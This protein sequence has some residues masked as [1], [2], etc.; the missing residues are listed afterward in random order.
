M[1]K[2][3]PKCKEVRN[4]LFCSVC[5]SKLVEIPTTVEC[6]I[7]NH[8]EGHSQQLNQ[9]VNPS[10]AEKN[11]DVFIVPEGTTVVK[12]HDFFDHRFQ[13]KSAILPSTLK[14][15]GVEAFLY[16]EFHEIVIPEGVTDIGQNAFSLS[17]SLRSVTLPSTLKKIGDF[18]FAQ[19]GLEEITIPEGI[20]EIRKSTF[21]SCSLLTSVTLPST[22]EKIGAFA[23][24]NTALEEII[25]PESVKE[26]DEFAFSECYSLQSVK[27]PDTLPKIAPSAFKD[28]ALGD[29]FFL[30]EE[31]EGED[32]SVIIPEGTT[33]ISKKDFWKKKIQT[34]TLPTTLKIIKAETFANS[35]IQEIV[36]P[37][38][39]TIIEEKAFM[40]CSLLSSVTLPSTLKKI[41]AYAFSNTLL[42]NIIIPENVIKIEAF[43]FKGTM[44]QKV[45]IYE[46]N[47]IED[48][49][50]DDHI[51]IETLVKKNILSQDN[52]EEEKEEKNKTYKDNNNNYYYDDEEED[53][54]YDDEDDEDNDDDDNEDNEDN[55]EDDEDNDD[56][57]NDDEDVYEEYTV[58]SDSKKDHSIPPHIYDKYLI[59]CIIPNGVGE[60]TNNT[61]EHWDILKTITLPASIQNIDERVFDACKE[62][63]KINIPMGTFEH[64]AEM[65]PKY[66]FL[67][68][69]GTT[70]NKLFEIMHRYYGDTSLMRH[71]HKKNPDIIVVKYGVSEI[72]SREF[73]K[74]NASFVLI[75]PS[76]EFI[77][78]AAFFNSNIKMMFIPESVHEIE[79][80][81]FA[82]CSELEFVYLPS[83]TVLKPKKGWLDIHLFSSNRNLKQIIVP[84]GTYEKYKEPLDKMKAGK[85]LIEK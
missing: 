55:E 85:F 17:R 64:F 71:I 59:E 63:I 5:G 20:T 21:N 46:G 40:N 6:E 18:A 76:V 68:D 73:E 60:V 3:C 36:I 28:T 77:R 69:D 8:V 39:V 15:I 24:A 41:G 52:E 47:E 75:P 32:A 50:F 72:K 78:R 29:H 57:D 49:A 11:R 56:E 38:G 13:Y 58:E 19:T 2:Y 83:N 82:C 42:E 61:I 53:E 67:L 84:K 66:W 33:E 81:V 26:I 10:N 44:L 23:F 65:L 31:E 25:I 14:K 62:L 48:N 34:V 79:T 30:K 37:E 22:L 4:D 35:Q 1:Q 27:L 12:K 16:S 74:T 43:T 7:K 45:L 80:A 51:I 9:N 70:N 54:D